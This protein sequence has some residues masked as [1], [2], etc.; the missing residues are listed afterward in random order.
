VFLQLHRIG[1]SGVNRAY[2]HLVKPT[3]LDVFFEKLTEFSMGN[4]VPDAPDSN[5]MVF[6][7]EIHVFLQLS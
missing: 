1:L 2:L 4:N 3:L 6:F 5:K 7:Q